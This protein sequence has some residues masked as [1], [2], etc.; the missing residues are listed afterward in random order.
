[1]AAHG[2]DGGPLTPV[3]I[4]PQ[5]FHNVAQ[6]FCDRASDL[7]SAMDK[8][9]DGLNNASGVAG[10]DNSAKK[11]DAAYQPAVTEL[12]NAFNRTVNL[13]Y[14]IASGIDLSATNHWRADAD[15]TP[16][17]GE[18][19]PWSPVNASL[20]LP[21]SPPHGSLVGKPIVS[22]PPPFDATIPLGNTDILRAMG[23]AL[24][25]AAN[26]VDDITN[27]LANDL[28]YLFESS[29]GAEL[30]AMNQFW[31]AIGG[32]SD[33]AILTALRRGCTQLAG[34]LS[35][36]ADWIDHTEDQIFDAIVNALKHMIVGALAGIAVGAVVG[37]F[38][39]GTGAIPAMIATADEIGEGASLAVTVAGVFDI[40]FNGA[41]AAVGAAAGAV[42][43]LMTA[44]INATPD[45]NLS[46]ASTTGISDAQETESADNLANKAGSDNLPSVKTSRKQLEKKFKHA[47][48]FGVTESR[49]AAG[50]NEFDDVIK[51]FV[52]SPT[53]VRQLG[54]YR[55]DEVVMN[56]DPSTRLII[57]QDTDGQFVS[58]WRLDDDQY[59]N[60]SIRG[61]L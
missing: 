19:P 60:V 39:G 11:F 33:T 14:D 61:S 23:T 36:Y 16:G 15:A 1:M 22:V 27:S 34:V 52:D 37:L 9:F 48:D 10:V 43:T 18:S 38:T 6:R 50:F 21:H 53:T 2:P 26:T 57:I 51:K 28:K 20:F 17:G 46:S 5:D 8:L 42:P 49:G 47:I 44:A 13:L 3:K 32:P 55:G 40:A 4:D 12:I 56:Y 58:G 30:D 45:P 59:A 41:Y 35:D 7:A 24:T 31:N 29:E 54:T 25:N